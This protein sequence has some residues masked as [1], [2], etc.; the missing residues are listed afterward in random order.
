MVDDLCSTRP[1]ARSTP[2]PG[3]M[4]FVF[5]STVT[6]PVP[7]WARLRAALA[8]AISSRVMTTP[9]CTTSQVFRW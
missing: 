7:G 8:S 6:S 1:R 5:I 2:T 4:K 3:C 9:P